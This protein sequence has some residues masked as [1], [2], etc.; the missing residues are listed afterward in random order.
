MILEDKDYVLWRV[1]WQNSGVQ[2]NERTFQ[3]KLFHDSSIP[4][5]LSL[6]LL[7]PAG[8]GKLHT[9]DA[10][11]IGRGSRERGSRGSHILLL[12]VFLVFFFFDVTNENN[13]LLTSAAIQTDWKKKKKKS[14][15]RKRKFSH[16][17][18]LQYLQSLVCHGLTDQLRQQLKS[19]YWDETAKGQSAQAL[20]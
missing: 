13:P 9:I 19:H 18:R 7:L 8:K 14:N 11:L 4:P 15:I 6:L 1:G 17:A 12:E 20:A 16:R 10:V 2:V 5:L 3:P